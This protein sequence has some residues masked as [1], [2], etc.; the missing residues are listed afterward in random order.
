MRAHRRLSAVCG[1]VFALAAC[2]AQAQPAQPAAAPLA[3]WPGTIEL[4]VDASDVGQRIQRVRQRIPVQPGPLTLWY[5]QWIPGNHAPTGP[6]N[7]IAGLVMRANGQRIAWR[8]DPVDMYAFHL[9]V[10]TGADA[11]DIEFQYLSPTASDQGRV[12]MTPNLLS[13]QWH[14]VL[15]YPR[16]V[17]ARG[18]QV[19]PRLTLPAGWQSAS[20]LQVATRQGDTL[21]FAPVPLVTLVDSP[22]YAGRHFRRIV[23]DDGPR[24]VRLNVVADAPEQLQA[25]P[26]MLAAHK[27][28]V[29]QADRLFGPR[30]F[31]HYDFLLALS[32][33]FSGIGLEHM[34]SSE[35][36]HYAEYL[37]GGAPFKDNDLLPHEYV[38]AWNGKSRRPDTLWTPHFNTPMHDDLLWVYEGATQYWAMVLAARSGLWSIEQA[39]AVF[40]ELAAAQRL[41]RG[42]TWRPLQDT[43]S[44]GIIDFNDAPQAWESWQRG[45]DFYGAGALLWLDTDTRI[46]ELSGGRRSLDDFARGFFA[47]GDTDATAVATY[48]FDAVVA[49]LERVQPGDWGPWLRER[50]DG[51]SALDDGLA[52]GGWS[53]ALDAQS[54]AA[55]TDA[56]GA[57][58]MIDLR[59]SLGLRVADDGELLDVVWDG[60]AFAAGL[61]RDMTLVAIDGEAFSRTRLERAITRAQR[62]GRALE[63][64]MRQA[65]TYRTHRIDYRDGLRQPRLAR[66]AG[67]PDRLSAILAPR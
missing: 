27:A 66:I 37:A 18:V 1:L 6:I 56:E 52:R 40:A 23:L 8:R 51:D 41:R 21:Q 9:Q 50:L 13:L 38:H 20:A 32:D 29:T 12:A 7:Q 28:L 36:G 49:A 58:G 11:L 47:A 2:A 48:G 46:R 24:P 39:R 62:D 30:P 25:S 55:V 34:Q 17:D 4:Q 14:R 43:V 67:T 65:D 26:A 31:A 5:P 45:Y 44:Q 35:N 53:L 57:D 59:H 64:L 22:L 61:A 60:P 16:G 33:D 19:A 15:L 10:P 3:Q 54:N 42:R 63:L